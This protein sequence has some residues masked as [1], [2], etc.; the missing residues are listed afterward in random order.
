MRAREFVTESTTLQQDVS[1]ALPATYV[2]PRLQNQD[3]YLQYR[4]GVAL[5][6][7]KG[8]CDP[9]LE[10]KE[11]YSASSAWG[12]NQVI[13]SYAG[14]IDGYIDDALSHI[15]LKAS[16]KRLISTARSEES[17]TVNKTSPVP[18]RRPNRHGV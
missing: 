7:A 3:P 4:F 9:D 17:S 13:V 10:S 15:G 16:D 1:A 14:S 8:R 2:I 11:E 18:E 5:A 12:E 6:R